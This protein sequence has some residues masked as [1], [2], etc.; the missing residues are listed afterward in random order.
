MSL[1][2]LALIYEGHLRHICTV[3]FLREWPF[4]GV[5]ISHQCHGIREGLLVLF[6][7]HHPFQALMRLLHASWRLRKWTQTFTG[8]T[9]HHFKFYSGFPEIGWNRTALKVILMEANPDME[10][11]SKVS[12]RYHFYEKLSKGEKKQVSSDFCHW[13]LKIWRMCY[14]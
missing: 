3:Y 13:F 8:N 2:Y 5:T 14:D 9:N 6:L 11:C 4:V 10:W 7:L 1:L 12:W